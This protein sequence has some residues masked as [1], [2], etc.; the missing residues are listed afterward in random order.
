MKFL[1]A[2]SLDFVDP[3]YDFVND[4][5]PLDREV[6]WDDKYAHEIFPETPYDGLLVSKAIV[7]RRNGCGRYTS[8]LAMRFR[9]V[10]A[11]TFLRFDS[12]RDVNLPIFGDCGAFS[13]VN[14]EVPPYT[15]E[16][17]IDFYEDGAFTHGVSIDHIIFEYISDA[18]SFWEGIDKD[19]PENDDKYRRFCITLD[20]AE[21]FINLCKK[22][23]VGFEP[24]GVAQGWSQL[25]IAE[26]ARTLAK[27]GYKYIALGGMVPLSATEIHTAL[28][29]VH[30]ALEDYDDIRLHILGFAKADHLAEFVTPGFYPK[31][32]SIDTTSP[33]IRAFKDSQRNYY[34]PN[35]E[36]GLEYFTAIR[37]PQAI[38]NNIL[39]RGVKK[40]LY[41]P[42]DLVKLENDALS[43]LRLYD[44]GGVKLETALDA[45]LTYSRK[46]IFLSYSPSL[47]EVRK[48]D[49]LATLY[50]R[51][52]SQRPWSKCDCTICK[53]ISVETIIFRGSNRNKRR[54]MHNLR[55]FH[56]HLQRLR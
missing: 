37:I 49:K 1:F 35:Q 6:Y 47:A 39:K 13:Y 55:V 53:D 7:D 15:P 21:K 10:G 20:L 56:N 23:K 38:E 45:I 48:M 32:A 16:D 44:S 54:G 19:D 30:K 52:L 5:S 25:S 22:E 3:L 41:R 36:N 2:D 27:L 51:T 26:G 33:L 50:H 9:L 46:L 31:L 43:A 11:R 18:K 4:C 12:S 40:G 14:E 42:E 17:M 34:L 28:R 24:V 29:A 8:S